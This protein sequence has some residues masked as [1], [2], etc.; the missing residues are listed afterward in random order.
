[1]ISKDLLSGSLDESLVLLRDNTKQSKNM[2]LDTFCQWNLVK[3]FQL[4]EPQF[5][6]IQNGI[7]IFILYN[8]QEDQKNCECKL[9]S[10][11]TLTVM[12]SEFPFLAKQYS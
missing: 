10:P 8:R 5:S 2:D 12:N 3:S 4:S 11:W 6:I 7:I 1:M 9:C